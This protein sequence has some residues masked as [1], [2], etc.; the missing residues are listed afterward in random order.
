MSSSAFQ[1]SKMLRASIKSD[2]PNVDE[3]PT[4]AKPVMRSCPRATLTA[5]DHLV[6]FLLLFE[7]LSPTFAVFVSPRF[8]WHLQVFA[9]L[10]IS[11]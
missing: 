4:G 1:A 5:A 3:P 8:M 7:W 11:V 9:E 10:W 2:L 6:G